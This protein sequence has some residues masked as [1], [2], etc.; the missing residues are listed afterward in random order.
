MLFTEAYLK[1]TLMEI[2][3]Q[4]REILSKRDNRIG[5][6]FNHVLSLKTDE[7]IV[8]K[9]LSLS[10]AEMLKDLQRLANG[11]GYRWDE[12][13][14][15]YSDVRHSDAMGIYMMGFGWKYETLRFVNLQDSSGEVDAIYI[16][17]ASN[18]GRYVWHD[19]G[20]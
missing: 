6:E 9:I 11:R 19:K 13:V 2:V 1:R 5:R 17:F 20:F 16:G 10:Y 14:T 8:D 3:K 12:F 18:F 4:F 7:E 15:K